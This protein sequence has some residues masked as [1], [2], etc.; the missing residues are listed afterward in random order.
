MDTKEAPRAIAATKTR[1]TMLRI[2]M[3]IEPQGVFE[4]IKMDEVTGRISLQ[5]RS[6]E[7]PG[8]ILSS[9][10]PFGMSPTTT[11]KPHMTD[12]SSRVSSHGISEVAH[13]Q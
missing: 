9:S 10:W 1:D 12:M 2:L 6:T 4:V 7:M 11:F 8:F 3:L 13:C 5:Q